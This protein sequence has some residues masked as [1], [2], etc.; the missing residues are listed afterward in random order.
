MQSTGTTLDASEA[1][2]LC[3]LQAVRRGGARSTLLY[4]TIGKAQWEVLQL[5]ASVAAGGGLARRV[6]LLDQQAQAQPQLRSGAYGM[7]G[8]PA[9]VPPRQAGLPEQQRGQQLPTGVHGVHAASEG[10]DA[11]QQSLP[12]QQAGQQL[13]TV[14]HEGS[15]SMQVG[16]VGVPDEQPRGSKGNAHEGTPGLQADGQPEKSLPS[17]GAMAPSNPDRGS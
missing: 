4:N 11:R 13:R 15:V 5:D 12:D 14:E 17:H 2:L 8:T 9:G 7:H 6:S 1:L 16:H 10:A 3:P